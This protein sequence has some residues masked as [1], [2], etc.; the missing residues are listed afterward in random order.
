MANARDKI[1]WPV[2]AVYWALLATASLLPSGTGPLKGWDAA[3]AP[4]LQD[5]LHLPAYAGL[6]VLLALAW[7]VRHPVKVGSLAAIAMICATFGGV[8]ELAQSVIPGRTCSLGD[9]LV[10]VAGAT[11]G[12]LVAL[13][14][15]RFLTFRSPGAAERPAPQDIT[16]QVEM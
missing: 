8:M 2:A 11:L 16:K 12:F 3:I 10:N 14:G 6:V 13:V 15:R 1:I 9:A 5:A 4:D 7:S